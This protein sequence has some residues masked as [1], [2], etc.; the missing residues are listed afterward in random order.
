MSTRNPTVNELER[1]WKS[2]RAR[3]ISRSRM[4]QA[5]RDERKTAKPCEVCEAHKSSVLDDVGIDDSSA[6]AVIVGGGPHA[7]AALSALHERHTGVEVCII[8]AGDHFMQ[9]WNTRFDGLEIDM[10]R[11]P[12][13]AHPAA[14]DP[15]ALVNFAVAEGRTSE[16]IKTPIADGNWL[17]TTDLGASPLLKALPSQALFKDFC[18]SLA[19][20]LPHRWL[21]GTAERVCKDMSTGKFRVHYKSKADQRERK[22]IA[23]AVILATGPVG[24][25]NV[26][27]PFELHLSA[28]SQLI[29]HTE[30]LLAE[31]T[32]CSLTEQIAKRCQGE[33]SRVL[34][35]GGGLSAAQSALAAFRAGHQVVLRS[36]KPLQTRDFDTEATWLDV[37]TAAPLRFEFLCLPMKDRIGAIRK[38]TPS[39]SVPAAYMEQLL[40]FSQASTAL[41]AALTLEVDA[42]IDK[43]QVCIDPSGKHIL[44]NGEPFAMIILA[45]GVVTVPT[46]TPLYRSVE[47]IFGAQTVNGLPRVDSRLRWVPTENLFVLGANAV[48][49]LGPGGRNLMGA[50]RG[51]RIVSNELQGL[52]RKQYDCLKADSGPSVFKN[53][54]AS[55][56]DRLRFGDGGDA[57]MDV[58][59]QLLHLSPKAETAIRSARNGGKAAVKLKG[60]RTPL[61]YLHVSARQRRA[62][63]W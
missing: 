62:T 49:E 63:Y 17:P 5:H 38:A 14:F 54:Y 44:V 4:L 57:E 13:F 20:K 2:V 11:S 58:L 10:L 21:S 50:M 28:R 29:I 47:E 41:H 60:E 7:L 37:R 39:G 19:A 3:L 9:A 56:G 52:I 32:G 12:A 40:R 31:G 18:A 55:L 35:I 34:V 24:K 48:L 25:W 8:D 36:R 45:T 42:D 26:P 46:C 61:A 6:F 27:A 16:L 23:H 1:C 33:S 15:P 53:L 59:A 51:A 30:G 22:V 43:S